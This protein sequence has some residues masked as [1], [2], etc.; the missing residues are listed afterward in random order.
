MRLYFHKIN[1]PKQYW[2]YISLTFLKEHLLK[3]L[4]CKWDFIVF[5]SFININKI[6][7]N[8]ISKL[9]KKESDIGVLWTTTCLKKQTNKQTNKWGTATSCHK[10]KKKHNF[11]KE[12]KKRSRIAVK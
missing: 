5:L 6:K 3:K 4:N 12:N 7:K 1:P 11:N 2:G 8:D 9:P 10:K